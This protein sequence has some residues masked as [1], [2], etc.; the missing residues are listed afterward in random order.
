MVGFVER[1]GYVDV[2]NRYRGSGGARS[3]RGGEA[4]TAQF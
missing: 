2:K 4:T 1:G 3:H